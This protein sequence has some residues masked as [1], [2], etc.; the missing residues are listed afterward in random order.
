[1]IANNDSFRD[2]IASRFEGL[3]PV[4]IIGAP[5]ASDGELLDAVQA[6]SGV[7]L[8]AMGGQESNFQRGRYTGVRSILDILTT[9]A[10][11]KILDAG[12]PQFEILGKQVLLSACFGWLVFQIESMSDAS[13]IFGLLARAERKQLVQLVPVMAA[14][15]A[16]REWIRKLLE[17]EGSDSTLM[18]Q[19]T[20][21]L[22]EFKA[23]LSAVQDLPGRWIL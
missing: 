20:D 11:S 17:L 5:K 12:D 4:G 6:V 19:I 21:D 13:L 22:A 18:V 1:M 8:F 2:E 15:Q 3:R 7:E 16:S 9:V 23:K 14:N 10:G